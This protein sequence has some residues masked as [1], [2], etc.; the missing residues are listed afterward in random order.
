MCVILSLTTGPG[1]API[2]LSINPLIQVTGVRTG[3]QTR[4]EF[5][6][7][8][9]NLAIILEDGTCVDDGNEKLGF[10]ISKYTVS[11]IVQV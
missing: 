7:S 9:D 8:D 2:P 5:N 1:L 10:A 4:F 11:I 6:L 3:R